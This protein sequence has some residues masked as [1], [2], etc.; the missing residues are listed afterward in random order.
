M[1]WNVFLFREKV[2]YH[3][4]VKRKRGNTQ[5]LYTYGAPERPGLK[6]FRAGVLLWEHV[7]TKKRFRPNLGENDVAVQCSRYC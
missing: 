5:Y 1:E 6:V 7:L 2:V 4:I 3:V